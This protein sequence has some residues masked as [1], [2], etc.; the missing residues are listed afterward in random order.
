MM[1]MHIQY[2]QLIAEKQHNAPANQ[3]VSAS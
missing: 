1:A 3:L 2:V